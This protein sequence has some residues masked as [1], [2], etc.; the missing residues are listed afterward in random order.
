MYF[1]FQT[2]FRAAVKINGEL[3]GTSDCRH[4]IRREFADAPLVEICPLGGKAHYSAFYPDAE[5]LSAPPDGTTV[6]DLNGGYYISLDEMPAQTPFKVLAQEKFS[7]AVVTV[8]SENGLKLSVETPAD[9]YAEQLPFAADG[10]SVRREYVGGADV[11][12]ISLQGKSGQ[13]VLAYSAGK[14]KKLFSREVELFDVQNGFYTL[15]K[16][17]DVAKHEIKIFWDCSAE[18]REIRR[19]VRHSPKFR[20][21]LVCDKILPYAFIEE[22]SAGGDYTCYLAD[23]IK[24]NADKLGGYF[25]EFIGVCPPPPFRDYREIGLLKKR[26]ERRFA[27]EYFSFDMQDGK[28]VNVRKA[29]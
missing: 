18:F 3:C 4:K 1:Y 24:K 12:F 5:F 28:I 17:K 16:R 23:G 6:T 13:I 20:P 10:A 22:F 25:G 2:E 26:G 15:E 7:D 14:V 27:L 8:F 9:F 19:E 29:D 11:I 21:D